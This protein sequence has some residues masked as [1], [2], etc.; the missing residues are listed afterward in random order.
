MC[1]VERNV[2]AHIGR[3]R[4]RERQSQMSTWKG[5]T[6]II[7][8]EW[9]AWHT[10]STIHTYQNE[11]N[12]HHRIECEWN[13]AHTTWHDTCA[14]FVFVCV[15]RKCMHV[16]HVIFIYANLRSDWN[17]T[18]AT[19][20]GGKKAQQMNIID[21]FRVPGLTCCNG[22]ILNVYVYIYIMYEKACTPST[23]AMK[24]SRPNE[25]GAS[26][27]HCTT[28][29]TIDVTPSSEDKEGME[30]RLDYE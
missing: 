24:L 16:V 22:Y 20:N 23:M 21:K 14:L 5:E 6:V 10:V 18:T 2:H 19:L 3:E 29:C 8:M 11:K 4:E 1:N 12:E 17:A 9:A 7:G 28:K 26:H 30:N 25:Q 13:E 15:E 27:L